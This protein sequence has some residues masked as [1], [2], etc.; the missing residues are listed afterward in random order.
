MQKL[1]IKESMQWFS[2]EV[3]VTKVNNESEQ[4]GT[5]K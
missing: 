1:K 3:E 2:L 5:S 4:V